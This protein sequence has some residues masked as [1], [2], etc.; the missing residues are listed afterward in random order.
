M[1]EIE[2][3]SSM[4]NPSMQKKETCDA[5]EL[6]MWKRVSLAGAFVV[7]VLAFFLVQNGNLYLRQTSLSPEEIS[8]KVSLL[9][10][11]SS[12]AD[13]QFSIT[14]VSEQHGL[15][16]VLF[17]LSIE[18]VAKEQEMFITKDGELVV[19]Q[20]ALYEDILAQIEFAKQQE[21]LKTQIPTSEGITIFPTD[22]PP[23]TE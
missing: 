7:A 17:D 4:D 5:S 1:S 3:K 23:V 19:M 9:F 20:S 6:V 18:G 11:E 12:T 14:E 8:E 15:Y 22:I 10:E 13:D 21:L 16:Q 2:N